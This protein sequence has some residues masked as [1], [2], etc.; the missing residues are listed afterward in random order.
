MPVIVVQAVVTKY[1]APPTIRKV[2]RAKSRFSAKA[3]PR[4]DQIDGSSSRRAPIWWTTR[5]AARR[6]AEASGAVVILK[7]HQSL[8]A[9]PD[10]D[11]HI[12]PTGNPGMATGGSGDVLTGLL[13]ALLA[14]GYNALAAVQLAT[15]VHGLAGDLA[16]ERAAL[17][18]MAASDL[19]D[20][21]TLA[22][23]RLTDEDL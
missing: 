5:R 12:N 18:A 15:F 14:R 11:V 1:T 20:H 13:V 23:R 4:R 9:T 3:G 21:L 6:A 19:V 17:P 2:A 16:M 8:V 7:G 22:W 10:G